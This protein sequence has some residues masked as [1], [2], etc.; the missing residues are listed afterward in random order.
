[1][2]CVDT[3]SDHRHAHL[4]FNV[5]VKCRAKNDVGVRID[6]I[7]N[8]V[9]RF[10]NFVQRHVVAAGDVDQNALGALERNIV[11]KWVGDSLLSGFQRAA[12]AGRLACTHHGSAH[13][14][15]NRT[16]VS[17]VEVNQT[18]HDHKICNTANT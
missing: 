15:H 17:K 4:A 16:D 3:C 10:V 11:Q 12:F 8:F 5:L 9:G 1:M 14:G 7:A 18:R 6:L 2:L 13:L